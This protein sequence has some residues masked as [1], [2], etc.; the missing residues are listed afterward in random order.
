MAGTGSGRVAGN[1]PADVTSFVGRRQATAEVKRVLSAARLV[2]LTG[3]GGVGKSRLALHVGRTVRRRFP[4]GVWLVE[5]ATLSDP[6]LVEQTVAAA[7]GLRD[8][9]RRDPATVLAEFL[10][11]KHLLLILDNCE[12]VLDGC[13]HLSARLLTTVPRLSVLATSREPLGIPGEH[14]WPVPPLSLPPTEPDTRAPAGPRDALALFAD[15]AAAVAPG[16]ALSRDNEPVVARLCRRLDG[17][18]LAIE[19]A[20]ARMRVM[21]V[22]QLLVRLEDRFTLL[23]AGHLTALPR[24]HTLRATVEWSFELCSEA[25]R[26]LWARC[27]VFAGDFDL[28]AAEHVCAGPGL[29]HDEVFE[30]V[31][32][33]I[34]KSVLIREE[35][36][37]AVRYRILDTIRQYG[38]ERLAETGD[39]AGPCR[40]HRDYYLHLAEQADADSGGPRQPDWAKRLRIERANLFA[41]LDYCL[42]VPG[43]QRDGLR[44]AAAL[45]FYWIAC[46][47]VRDGRYWLDQ[48]LQ[49]N[50][51]PS[52]DRA[53]A[54]W[55][56]GWIA[57]VQGDYQAGLALLD[58]SRD[59][60]QQ[61]G[62]ETERTYATQHLGWARLATGDPQQAIPLL[63]QVLARHRASTRWTA[64]ALIIFPMQVFAVGT[65]GDTDHAMDLLDECRTICASLGERWA[66]SWTLNAAGIACLTAG[67]PRQA[68]AHLCECL[69]VKRDVT[70]QLGYPFGVDLLSWIAAAQGDWTRA[71][72]LQGAADTMWEPI[73]RPLFGFDALIDQGQ[74]WRT[75]THDALGDRAYHHALQHG[76]RMT[77]EQA[78][79]YAL[80][81]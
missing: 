28:D 32:G 63:D 81:E 26:L 41:A 39:P 15:R 70:D 43:Q 57:T 18:P 20:A 73:G 71:A 68:A 65:A 69:R 37:T 72:V 54:L 78:I 10:A 29:A 79:A 76:A 35:C 23:T 8:H 59:L 21:S 58:E 36:A 40:R 30:A 31:A 24:H 50:P 11:D 49:A 42:T 75:H 5:L 62:N 61:L 56:T 48:A 74:E 25:E 6:A 1:L 52:R 47:F 55:I 46:G 14:R 16:F 19:L 2:T 38:R 34:D 4:D 53:R 80:G 60:A 77:P 45:W 33:L 17:L 7:L 64:P 51:A 9:S 66:L 3:V 13:G 27:S 22:E 12:H 44:L 67:N